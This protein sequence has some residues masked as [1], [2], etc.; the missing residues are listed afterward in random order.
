MIKIKTAISIGYGTIEDCYE[1]SLEEWEGMSEEERE[2]FK[3]DVLDNAIANC[4]D[5]NV[6]E[7]V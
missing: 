6:W 7:E 2:N 1:V 3:Q 5:C 4:L